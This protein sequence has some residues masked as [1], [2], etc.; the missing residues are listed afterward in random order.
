VTAIRA[1]N[2]LLLLL[3]AVSLLAMP[4]TARAGARDPHPHALLQLVADGADGHLDHHLAA[5]TA[6][7]AAHRHP[8]RAIDPFSLEPN[9]PGEP[10]AGAPNA[11]GLQFTDAPSLIPAAAGLVWVFTTVLLA[12]PGAAL[13]AGKRQDL[14]WRSPAAPREPVR[15]PHSPPPRPLAPAA[16]S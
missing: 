8:V 14:A 12:G 6:N 1:C 5:G 7:P 10:L 16:G 15:L 4:V 11:P 13:L 9:L 2:L 3:A